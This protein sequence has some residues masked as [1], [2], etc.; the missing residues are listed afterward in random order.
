MT[1]SA[2]P[3]PQE[4]QDGIPPGDT[5]LVSTTDG[6]AADF[7]DTIVVNGVA[8]KVP[9][10]A[11]VLS[12]APGS[13]APQ[14]VYMYAVDDSLAEGTRV[15]TANTSVISA[16]PAFDGAIVRN[17]E[18]TI[19]DN[20]TPGV[21]LTQL[22]PNHPTVAD[23][24]TTVLEGTTI[25]GQSDLYSIQLTAA[26]IGTVTVNIAPA[27]SRVCLSSSSPQFSQSVPFSD[28]TLC[29]LAPE[30]Y[31]V[32]FNA[33]N[34]FI[35]VLITVNA[36]NDFATEDPQS[37]AL[38]HTI[39]P[40]GT[41]DPLYL[42]AAPDGTSQEVLERIYATVIDDESP[43]VF[44][45]QSGG[46]T[47]VTPSTT[48]DYT[49]RLTSQP[50]ADVQIAIVTDGQT[51]ASGSGLTLAAIGGLRA[52]QLFTGNVTVSGSTITLATGSE[53]GSFVQDGFTVGMRI[54]F[55]GTG[56]ADDTATNLY[57]LT[58]TDSTITLTGAAPLSGTFTGIGIS[59][60]TE[61]G[62]YT[63]TTAGGHTISYNFAAG[64]LTRDDGTSW[65]DSGFL[66][67]QLIRIDGDPTTYKI[68]SF[69][70]ANG[71]NL[72]VLQLTSTAKPLAGSVATTAQI[73]QW[74]EV[75]TFTPSDWYT[76]VDVKLTDDTNFTLPASRQ[77]L[78][79]FPKQQ[80]TLS[81]IQGPLSVE[82][83]TTN[84]DR[85]LHAAV[86][87]PGE[88]NG[89]LFAVAAQ[90][91]EWQ[92][93]DT[94][95]VYDDGSH[96]DQTGTLTSTALTGL[97]MGGDPGGV[98]D[99]SNLLPPTGVFPFG[100]P[101]IYP[102]GIS[103]GTITIDPVTHTFVTAG[104]V[105]T[106]E[107]LNILLGQGNDHL[108]I[109]STMVPGPDHNPDGSP[110]RAAAQGG[111]TTVHGGG[112][113]LMT[114]TGTFNASNPT[115]STGELVRID[116]LS[117]AGAGF[118]VGEQVT[119]TGGLSGS[120]TIAG[121]GDTSF[122]PGSALFLNSALGTTGSGITAT[123]SVSDDLQ[124]TGAFDLTANE[125]LRRDGLPWESLGFTYG[126]QVGIVGI[127]GSWTIVGFDNS[128]YGDG[129][130]LILSGPALT[131]TTNVAT[132]VA[133]T[134]RNRA[135][136]NFT[137]GTNTVT[138]TSGNLATSGLA[139][140]QQVAI[141]GV[142]GVRTITAITG[143]VLTLSGGPMA[144]AS[145]VGGTVS[146]VRIGGDDIVV[147]GG[148][149]TTAAGGPG[150][151]TCTVDYT[152][153]TP[154][155][156]VIY[157]DTSQDGLWY[158]GN[159]FEI[160]LHDFGPKPL[161]NDANLSVT[162]ANATSTSGTLTR[163]D[164]GSWI[165][166]GFAVGQELTLD[167]TA[168]QLDVIVNAAG[169]ITRADGGSWL[170]DGYAVGQL[171]QIDGATVGTVMAVTA[172]TLTLYMLTT[173]FAPEVNPAVA[174]NHL[175][176]VAEIGTVNAVTKTTLTLTFLTANFAHLVAQGTST[177]DVVVAT[178]VGNGA[179][180]FVFQLGDPFLYNGND[181]IDASAAFSAAAPTSLPSIGITAYGGPGDDTI[182]GS[183]TG[184]ILAGGSGND[185]IIGGRGD[186]QIFGDSGVNV[187]V[188]TRALTIPTVNSSSYA[189]RD[190]MV[191]G[192]DLLYGDG[193]G[194]AAN[195]PYQAQLSIAVANT[196]TI[197]RGDGGSWLT[198][199]FAAGQTAV[200]ID[201]V[202]VGD[203]LSVTA[204][205]ITLTS[206]TSAFNGFVGTTTDH[207]VSVAWYG[208]F[209][210][211]IIGDHGSITQD[212]SGPRDTTK[213]IPG[214]VQEI[215]TTL[216]VRTIQ[217]LQPD[218]AAND[219]IYGNGGD[220]ILIGDNGADAIDGGAGNDLIFGDSV[221]LDRSTHLNN[222]TSPLYEDLSGTQIYST[223]PSN[224]GALLVDGTPQL[225]PQGHASWGD[226]LITI[227]DSSYGAQ[228]V[229][230]GN[231]Y[232]AGGPGNDMIFG[233]L[234][235]DTIQGDGSIDY[236][237]DGYVSPTGSST[238]DYA[239]ASACATGGNPG[240]ATVIQRVGACRDASN[241]LDVSPS[242]DRSTDGSDYIEG[243]GGNDVIFGNQGQDDIVGG[244][245]DLFAG[246]KGACTTANEV[247]G[248]GNATGSCTR[249]D[250]SD[251]IFGGSGTQLDRLENGDLTP[252]GDAN[253]SDTIVGDNGD[254]IR[255]V[256][257]DG[258]YGVADGGVT[259]AATGFLSYNYDDYTN[260]LP[261]AQQEKIVVRGVK[262]IDYT[263]GG[264]TYN[265]VAVNDI[266]TGDEIHGENGD[267]FIYGGLGDDVLYGE[268][269]NDTIIGN[270]GSDWI[271]GGTGD[272]G[273]LGDDGEVYASRVSSSYG[274]PLN[275]IAA[276]D[277][278]QISLFIYTPGDAQQAVINVD[279]SLKYTIDLTPNS[280]DPAGLGDEANADPYYMPPVG[281]ANDIIYGGLGND[282]IHGGDG[283]DAL[284]GAEAPI[285][286]YT[287][288]YDVNGN[289][290]QADLESDYYHPL[291]PG[292]ALGYNP[293]ASKRSGADFALYDPNDPL[294]K[295]L[296][297]PVS[298]ALYK[299]PIDTSTDAASDN[300]A[301]TYL[302]W[303][304]NFDETEGPLDTVWAA[305]SGYPN[306]PTDGN[307]ILFGDLGND[308]AVGGTGR[309]QTFLGWG[310]DEVSEDDNLNTDGGLNDQTDTNP[311][312][313]DFAY[314]GAGRDV[315]IANTG[316]D[317]LVDWVGE[318]NSYLVPFAPFG[319]PTVSRTLQPQLDVFLLLLSQSDGADPTLGAEY[320]SDPTRNGE[321]FG[322]LGEVRQH[323]K[324]YWQDQTG[325]PR[326]PQAGNLPGG[327]R[328]V[329]VTSGLLPIGSP[330][331]QGIGTA[332][333]PAIKLP[334]HVSSGTPVLVPI[335]LH[336]K[337]KATAIVAVTDGVHTVTGSGVFDDSGELTVDLDLSSL[338][339]GTLT[340]SAV[341]LDANG[342]PSLPTV[343]TTI[344]DSV[345]PL[346]PALAAPSYVGLAGETNFTVGISGEAGSYAVWS[347]TDA[348]GEIILAESDLLDATGHLSF[349]VDVSSLADGPV[350]STVTLMDAAGN[351]STATVVTTTKMTVIPGAQAILINPADDSGTSK[352]DWVTNVSA[353]RFLPPA[354]GLTQQIYLNGVLY[355][356]QQLAD[357]VYIVSAT[358]T[359]A[360]GNVSPAIFAT[361]KLR[362]DTS[363]PNG[364]LSLGGTT[365]ANGQL[366]TS[367]A[368]VVITLSFGDNGGSGISS[369]AVSTNGGS[370]YGLA[371]QYISS[372]SVTLAD[373][374]YT[375]SVKVIDLAGNA[376]V[377]SK[378][379][380]VDTTAPTITATLPASTFDIGAA[381]TLTY[382]AT[383]LGSGV[384]TTT[385][386]LDGVTA[387]AGGKID[388]DTLTVGLHN[389]LVVSSDKL[390][391][392]STKSLS[393]TIVPT[394]TGLSAAI[395]DGG[396][397][398]LITAAEVSTLLS[399]VQSATKGNSAHAKLSQ[400][401]SMVQSASGKSITAAEATLLLNW[402]Q[403]LYNRS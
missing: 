317:R 302:D 391:N 299:G 50:T 218:N 190:L 178:R 280:L 328:D 292:N 284:S 116:G 106:I 150:S 257:T 333:S 119:L 300:Q 17:V 247:S 361:Q 215:Q 401:L 9:R 396:S 86:L 350:T 291:D 107:D 372:T 164:G 223:D 353:P 386:I 321:P 81:G 58:V 259:K 184:D 222:F 241:A 20:D 98:L 318:F 168:D 332:A 32:T 125:V 3:S 19:Y 278:S 320:G 109:D 16:D 308:W 52:S 344:K 194:S 170:A 268:A 310:N 149:S 352:T 325:G 206:L 293:V 5:F 157:G 289:L 263:A 133:V 70:S 85:S 367:S 147:T 371:Q 400:F 339:D 115:A 145:V 131:P 56:T 97:D 37:V 180:F 34:W 277:P 388:I 235:N 197:T 395:S 329:R 87:L 165:T 53:L 203:V 366:A 214:L 298:G 167:A 128:I 397:R 256:G 33:S 297:T 91:P 285:Q 296:L 261:L 314:G 237:S 112:N 294:R 279:G 143:N 61:E 122:G 51:D 387:I 152:T 179:P 286:S 356:G 47:L 381:V 27:S 216:R 224:S 273:L 192:Q 220:D 13:T 108:T 21:L 275:S 82:G 306:L 142:T 162:A 188:I 60:L 264:V 270:I 340:V 341:V 12:F 303:F 399:Q 10:R 267:D 394:L 94:L 64:T 71:G 135:T 191:A 137:V 57:V 265:P 26:P 202:T 336:G 360:A 208:N 41:T 62:T 177:H 324:G 315:L 103:Y 276:I 136:G 362:I 225:D 151:N 155:P 30:T 169:T 363:G 368:T 130:A 234:G 54:G 384:G 335:S 201:G 205:T 80:H 45:L 272:D 90:P 262:L 221:S 326:D 66:E 99:F 68:E 14:T 357:G 159:P 73:V 238:D 117:W 76:A 104:N 88:G 95:N 84:S 7:Y 196:G 233:E 287:N 283:D 77:N 243:G 161:P 6:S 258:K 312:Y 219:T 351:V 127:P 69:S 92:Q 403:D 232:I 74:A 227:L 354:S 383:D 199:G 175:I 22:D 254:I 382:S 160:S 153:C 251:L 369:M 158:G 304:L 348:A 365:L 229:Y 398:G 65:L 146:L 346:A 132:T 83:G 4:E 228:Q 140:G 393:F 75:V 144:P 31:S 111:L 379:I 55:T 301:G 121:F 138:F 105:T 35:P 345:A 244:N 389:L 322:E 193:P 25:T 377:V 378:S 376:T 38:V 154:S 124:V 182:I 15:V 364:T 78:T 36:R 186:D 163:N 349:S 101:G 323:D 358:T 311:S 385:V 211:I 250:G 187:D 334:A 295:I 181:V 374:L 39:D 359:D 390:G 173:D 102:D 290:I 24:V 337:A 129:T 373:G 148:S 210:D 28:P 8:T 282:A 114:L 40:T 185:T 29:P 44:V 141:T 67:G 402:A 100:E 274:E 281:V 213:P 49:L 46:S 110:N 255:L 113:A 271:S 217:S 342:N 338:S 174:E 260:A 370:T 118:S 252:Q 204:S 134:N 198:A 355:T 1:V 380:L 307:D 126:Q 156:L 239:S 63:G 139:V 231:D 269:Q 248:F 18:V 120:Y 253:D 171:V 72:N 212:V 375:I 200:T 42:A 245:S 48:D 330:G 288:N 319:E 189:N 246:L 96:Q 266:G 59:S 347:V 2:S 242:V 123:V 309:D 23:N 249:P 176:S 316:G 343:T 209:D 183:Q 230:Y 11:V 305:G 89:P 43:G 327:K 166:D 195:D 79:V 392:T 236:I 93:I 313:E 207:V 331:T 226:Y 240:S 172:T